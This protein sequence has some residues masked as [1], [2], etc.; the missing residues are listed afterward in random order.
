VKWALPGRGKGSGDSEEHRR[1]EEDPLR[2]ID[3]GSPKEEPLKARSPRLEINGSSVGL[4]PTSAS[5]ICRASGEP[6][7]STALNRLVE[8]LFLPWSVSMSSDAPYWRP[9]TPRGQYGR[10][11]GEL[12]SRS[13]FLDKFRFADHTGVEQ[14]DQHC[15]VRKDLPLRLAGWFRHNGQYEVAEQVRSWGPLPV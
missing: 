3:E 4:V 12:C 9:P 11:T 14:L 5:R 8:A 13:P 10:S 2:L 7:S 6:H 15:A 1:D